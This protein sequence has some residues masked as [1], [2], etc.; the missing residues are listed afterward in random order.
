M[1]KIKQNVHLQ[2]NSGIRCHKANKQENLCINQIRFCAL[3]KFT[4]KYCLNGFSKSSKTTAENS[5]L[6]L[7]SSLTKLSF[8]KRIISFT[9]YTGK[10]IMASYYGIIWLFTKGYFFLLLYLPVSGIM[11]W[12]CMRKLDA[13][14]NVVFF[15]DSGNSMFPSGIFP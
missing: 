1:K 13:H 5:S 4:F 14:F 12:R 7:Y 6:Y 10:G 8:Q 15:T 11:F 2:I 3:L 9:F